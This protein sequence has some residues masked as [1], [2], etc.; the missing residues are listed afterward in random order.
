MYLFIFAFGSL[1]SANIVCFMNMPPTLCKLSEREQNKGIFSS[2][3]STSK[4]FPLNQVR[5]LQLKFQQLFLTIPCA[6]SHCMKQ[7][8]KNC[9]SRNLVCE[10]KTT[11]LTWDKSHANTPAGPH[12]HLSYLFSVRENLD[13]KQNSKFLKRPQLLAELELHGFYPSNC[14]FS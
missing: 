7:P 9:S 12:Q 10:N 8:K 14:T 4:D 6:V 1:R 3:E 2:R 11:F 5:S 13:G